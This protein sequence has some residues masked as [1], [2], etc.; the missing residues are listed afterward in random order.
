MDEKMSDQQ[1]K[2]RKENKRNYLSIQSKNFEKYREKYKFLLFFEQK[3]RKN[4][5]KM[6]LMF[7]K[8]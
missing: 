5:D 7:V 8:I 4:R 6:L 2:P 1:E 3:S